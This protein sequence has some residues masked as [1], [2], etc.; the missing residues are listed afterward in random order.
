[1]P[2]ASIHDAIVVGAGPAGATA[3][4]TLAARGVRPLLVDRAAFPRYKPC[5]GAITTR[6]L[7]RFPY[8]PKALAGISTQWI[9][10]LV[11][12]GPSGQSAE[13]RSA[14][15]AVLTIRRLE[16][17]ALLVSLAREAGAE[18]LEGMEIHDVFEDRD[19]VR[20]QT[21]DG[22]TFAA[23]MVVAADGVHG[24]VARRLRLLNG[25]RHD[26]LAVDLMEE[27]PNSMLR[28]S[29]PEALWVSY[30][31]PASSAGGPRSLK[32]G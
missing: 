17:D 19:R 7:A 27:T 28:A 21:R 12:Q 15:P 32:D 11:L 4:R 29:D 14:S 24:V 2:F 6:V 8:L 9:S 16:F 22:R 20:L 26:A 18:L 31:F 10:K 1:V 23:R 3:A 30:G 25:W 13:I 5:G